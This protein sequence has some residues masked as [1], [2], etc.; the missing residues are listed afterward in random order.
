VRAEGVGFRT[1]EMSGI[2]TP[3]FERARP[4]LLLVLA[5]AALLAAAS[6]AAQKAAPAPAHARVVRD[7]FG[8]VA[9]LRYSPDGRELVRVCMFGPVMRLDTA[10]FETARTFTVGMRMLA[11]SPSGALI[12]T[13]EGSDGARIWDAAAP[14]KPIA[15]LSKKGASPFQEVSQVD[16]PLRVLQAKGENRS[17]SVFWAD[18]SP[19]GRRVATASADGHVK[20]WNARS[21]ALEQDLAMG[22]TPVLV[23]AF[24]PDGQT[25]VAGD[26]EGL[27]HEWSFAKSS[28]TFTAHTP[29]PVT[30]AVFSPDGR[31]L[32]T[33]HRWQGGHSVV[34]WSWGAPRKMASQHDGQSAAFSKDGK[35]LAIGGRRIELLDAASGRR[36]RSIDLPEM[37]MNDASPFLAKAAE[38]QGKDWTRKIPI[39]VTAL[40]FSPDGKT[41]AAGLVDGTV[42]LVEVGR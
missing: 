35:L 8:P 17:P 34:L 20:I 31:T 11:Y 36:I 9:F 10:T 25:I 14:G 40:V 16:A 29:G 24:A 22:K 30:G 26:A 28:E 15:E 19:D 32:V 7:G 37:T 12:A 13:A 4:P 1:T 38:K 21:G 33:S 23:A 42:R 39:S 41:L 18:F 27:L 5:A 2:P 6:G 3:E